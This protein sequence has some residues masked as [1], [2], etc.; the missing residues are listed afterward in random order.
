MN[1]TSSVVFVVGLGLMGALWLGVAAC[2]SDAVG[3]NCVSSTGLPGRIVANADDCLFDTAFCER[4]G[5]GHYCT[6]AQPLVCPAGQVPIAFTCGAPGGAGG[7]TGPGTG[8]SDGAGGAGGAAVSGGAGATGGG[9]GGAGCGNASSCPRQPA[10]QPLL[11]SAGLDTGFETCD[12]GTDRRR[13]ALTCPLPRTNPA[14]AGV[15]Y[16]SCM[17]DSDCGNGGVCAEAHNLAGYSGCWMGCRQDADC[18]SGSICACSDPVGQC[19]PAACATNADCGP[20]FGCVA[21]GEGRAGACTDSL[22]YPNLQKVRYVCERASDACRSEA[23]CAGQGGSATG[24]P[25]GGA[26]SKAC[27]FDGTRRVCGYVCTGPV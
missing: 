6:G 5:D 26:Y 23:D 16:H 27:L 7:Q 13:A 14:D 3:Q 8:G 24:L 19:V 22:D 11:N 17:A 15:V 12:D 1:R 9:G 10:C 25:D 21:S 18:G 2:R 20:G 4:R